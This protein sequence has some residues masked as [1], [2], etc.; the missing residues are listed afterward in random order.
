MVLGSVCA[1]VG[2]VCVCVCVCVCV[3]QRETETE[4]R[5]ETETER[6]RDRE[7]ETERDR[8]RERQRE[9][10][11]ER[12][13][14]KMNSG[15]FMLG[16]RTTLRSDSSL[17]HGFWGGTQVLIGV[18]SP[19]PRELSPWS[20]LIMTECLK[21]FPSSLQSKGI[22]TKFISLFF[23][24]IKWLYCSPNWSLAK[25]LITLGSHFL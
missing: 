8:D 17:H 10:E 3:W 7:T 21:A 9:T 18:A 16:Q 5:R 24:G 2:W 13:R 20:K 11:T 1:C 14:Q 15:S 23:V 22:E 4:T 19:F 12:Q 6:D 25:F